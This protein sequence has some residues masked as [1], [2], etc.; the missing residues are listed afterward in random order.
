MPHSFALII[1]KYARNVRSGNKRREPRR[2]ESKIREVCSPRARARAFTGTGFSPSS[3]AAATVYKCTKRVVHIDRDWRPYSH[4]IMKD[5]RAGQTRHVN[6][7]RAVPCQ[8]NSALRSPFRSESR[9]IAHLK[10]QAACSSGMCRQACLSIA[11]SAMQYSIC[12][13]IFALCA[14]CIASTQLYYM[15]TH[16]LRG[17]VEHVWSVAVRPT[18]THDTR[19][20]WLVL[21]AGAMTAQRKLVPID[22]TPVT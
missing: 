2:P 1:T 17:S 21:L 13:R 22:L 12:S 9:K 15:Y 19:A 8:H 3:A 20:C 18:K 7:L 16:L 11:S 10:D 4:E 6:L 5:K 14:M